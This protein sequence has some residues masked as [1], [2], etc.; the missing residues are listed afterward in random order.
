[1][2]P[3]LHWWQQKLS[4][5]AADHPSALNLAWMIIVRLT[6]FSEPIVLGIVTGTAGSDTSGV[7]RLHIPYWWSKFAL[8]A[9]LGG[10]RSGLDREEEGTIQ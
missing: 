1:M 3:R 7:C 5:F 8:S 9:T 2:G 4:A 6:T 10:W